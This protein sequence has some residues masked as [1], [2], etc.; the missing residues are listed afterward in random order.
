M[1]TDSA[2]A[3]LLSRA[4]LHARLRWIGVPLFWIGALGLVSSVVA[5]ILG[6]VGFLGVGL[7]MAATGISLGS[8]GLNNDTALALSQRAPRERLSPDLRAEL[9]SELKVNRV[10]VTGLSPAPVAAL[11]VIAL[12]LVLHAGA[13]YTLLSKF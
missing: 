5:L 8:F 2:T 12:A 9:E 4:T 13:G 10:A 3:E 11:V 1:S 7:Y 6:K